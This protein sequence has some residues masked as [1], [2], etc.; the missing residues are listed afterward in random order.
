M[1]AE[2][3]TGARTAGSSE[4]A[5]QLEDLRSGNRRRFFPEAEHPEEVGPSQVETVQMLVEYQ[6]VPAGK[7]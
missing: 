7:R 1:R 3:P 5:Q 4:P 2:I 6:P